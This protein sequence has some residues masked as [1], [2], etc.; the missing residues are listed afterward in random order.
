MYEVER[1]AFQR[2]MSRRDWTETAAA[3]IRQEAYEAAVRMEYGNK[4]ATLAF[5]SL[6]DLAD[7]RRLLTEQRPELAPEY[8]RL[9]DICFIGNCNQV[10]NVNGVR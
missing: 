2:E 3:V 7:K 1:W 9:A 4:V 10:A 6:A 5:A 8:Q